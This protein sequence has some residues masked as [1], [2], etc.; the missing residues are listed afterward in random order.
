MKAQITAALVQH[1]II[2]V[3]ITFKFP[4]APASPN[5]PETLVKV[6]ATAQHIAIQMRIGVPAALARLNGIGALMKVS[7][8]PSILLIVWFYLK[9]R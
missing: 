5:I 4:A 7:Q 9:R 8:A 2:A 6:Q 1:Q 3:L